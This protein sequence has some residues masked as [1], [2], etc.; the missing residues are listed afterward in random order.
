MCYAH[1]I[2]TIETRK[3]GEL[4]QDY[5]TTWQPYL[6]SEVPIYDFLDRACVCKFPPGNTRNYPNLV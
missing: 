6:D 4:I 3:M 2:D 5:N 1:A